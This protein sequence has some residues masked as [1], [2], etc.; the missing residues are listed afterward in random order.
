MQRVLPWFGILLVT[1]AGCATTPPGPPEEVAPRIASAIDEGRTEEAEELFEASTSESGASE[2]L[3]PLL[4]E[5]ANTRYQ[6]GE[7][8][9]SAR[10]LGFMARCYPKSRAVREARVY[11]LF[12][13]RAH[14]DT[15]TPDLVKD[16]SA[17][18]AE[19]RKAGGDTPLWIGLVEAQLA[20]D[21]GERPA[22][23][24]AFAGFK[25]EWNGQPGELAIYV[26]DID[27]YL[28]SHP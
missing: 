19:L 27:R 13:E 14:G 2:Q 24:E 7:C 21:R 3:Y 12:L 5:E 22:A 15:P 18:V 20:I 1:L 6:K 9:N 17:A 11:A 23:R 8:A 10:L 26:D 16:L 28:I 4:Y 25:K